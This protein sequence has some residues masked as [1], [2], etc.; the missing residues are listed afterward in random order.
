LL[1]LP[2]IHTLLLFL[3]LASKQTDKKAH[4]KAVHFN[5]FVVTINFIQTIIR[6]VIKTFIN[7]HVTFRMLALAHI[8]IIIIVISERVNVK[9]DGR[10]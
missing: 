6:R 9:K 1:S 4:I 7:E 8:I 5:S 3:S 2:L 10:G